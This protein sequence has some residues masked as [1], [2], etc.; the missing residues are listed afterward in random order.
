MSHP[1]SFLPICSISSLIK[2]CI[3]ESLY[4]N[5]LDLTTILFTMCIH[6]TSN[7]N[8]KIGD[9]T[10]C[11]HRESYIANASFP[12]C[13]ALFSTSED[14]IMELTKDYPQEKLQK[15]PLI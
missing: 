13:E 15:I 12:F 4:A 14:A 10:I 11:G 9:V 5:G 2:I 6:H 3:N 1:L 7:F 8:Y